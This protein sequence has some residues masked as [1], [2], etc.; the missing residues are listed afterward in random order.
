MNPYHRAIPTTKSLSILAITALAGLAIGQTAMLNLNTA[1]QQAFST[2]PDLASS[3][4]TLKNAQAD[5]AAK[6]ADPSTLIVPLIQ[7]RN[8]ATLN[9]VQLRAKKTMQS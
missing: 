2:G 4:A 3:V 9:A 8:T 6:E 5:L 7:A 1:I